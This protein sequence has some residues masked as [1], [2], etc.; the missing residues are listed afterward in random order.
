MRQRLKEQDKEFLWSIETSAIL[1]SLS[2]IFFMDFVS[3]FASVWNGAEK[4]GAGP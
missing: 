3:K 1:H 2:T 4:C